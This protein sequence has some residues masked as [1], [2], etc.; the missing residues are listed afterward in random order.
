MTP[1]PD[2]AL[3]LMPT[4]LGDVC[5]ATPT[6]RALRAHWPDAHLTAA[7]KPSMAALAD[8]LPGIDRAVAGPFKGR[9]RWLR[10]AGPFDAAVV[11]PNSFRAAWV[12]RRSGARQRIG[13]SGNARSLLLND[14]APRPLAPDPTLP[15]PTVGQYLALAAHLGADTGDATLSLHVPDDQR[16]AAHEVLHRLASP[17]GRPLVVLNPG[18][19][20]ETKRWPAESFAALADAL[21]DAG[22]ATAV[23]GSPAESDVLAAVVRAARAPVGHLLDAGLKLATLPAVLA[24]AALLVTNDTGPRHVAAAVGTPIVTLFGPTPPEWTVLQGVRER[25]LLAGGPRRA[26]EPIVS[27]KHAVPGREMHRI[28]AFAVRDACLALLGE[29]P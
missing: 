15:V 7:L 5:M 17:S 1:P 25:Q 3:I 14:H 2:R 9:L 26:D 29:S 13:F 19:V 11:L 4:W 6:L 18:A 22:Y 10:D 24:Q 23:T 27:A 28:P 21:H 16:V 8:A 12:A 20:R